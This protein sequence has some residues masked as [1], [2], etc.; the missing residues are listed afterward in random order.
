MIVCGKQALTWSVWSNRQ[1][2]SSPVVSKTVD[3]WNC[4]FCSQFHT[5]V[6]FFSQH[7]CHHCGKVFCEQ[8]TSK[9]VLGSKS[10]KPHPVCNNCYVILNKDSTSTFY[11]TTLADDNRWLWSC[12]LWLTCLTWCGVIINSK[13]GLIVP[14]V[15]QEHFTL[16]LHFYKNRTRVNGLV[17]ISVWK[18]RATPSL[19]MFHLF[20]RNVIDIGYKSCCLSCDV[21]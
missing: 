9:T 12:L 19:I 7:H 2:Q 10:S 5:V 3:G 4:L 14:A 6:F 16:L 11:N 8:C 18:R 17:F 21:T 13:N 20:V 1:F 15:G